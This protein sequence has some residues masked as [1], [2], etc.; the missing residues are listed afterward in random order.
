MPINKRTLLT[1]LL[2]SSL[3]FVLG[4]YHFRRQ[5]SADSLQT[6]LHQSSR[7]TPLS[8]TARVH[9]HRFT[10]VTLLPWNT[11]LDPLAPQAGVFSVL[12]VD[13]VEVVPMW[14]RVGR[15]LPQEAVTILPG[16]TREMVHQLGMWRLAKGAYVVKARWRWGEA[17]KDIEEAV[18]VEID[19]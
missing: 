19:V 7:T 9:N 4:L 15:Q 18:A 2:T 11:P 13:G 3:L 6:T 16:E 1:I 8:I 10:P 12:D 17:E 5:Q 14:N